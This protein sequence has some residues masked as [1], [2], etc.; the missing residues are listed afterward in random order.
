MGI[1][2]AFAFVLGT[3]FSTDIATA[4]KPVTEVFL[5]NTEPIPVTG[6]SSS[7]ACPAEN[8][9]HWIQISF[10]VAVTI[11]HDTLPDLIP[12]FSPS[13]R[14]IY[15][16]KL[17]Q[18]ETNEFVFIQELVTDILID[19]GYFNGTNIGQPLT[20]DNVN[21]FDIEYSTLCVEN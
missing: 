15:E 19:Q 16:I 3:V 18:E 7:P 17:I 6:I 9:Q 14:N 1:A 10:S 13:D 2:V 21:L 20:L 5:T 11:D 4:T 12:A 8:I